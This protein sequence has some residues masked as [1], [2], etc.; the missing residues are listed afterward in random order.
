MINSAINWDIIFPSQGVNHFKLA[1]QTRFENGLYRFE[2]ELG[3][4]MTNR[5]IAAKLGISSHTAG[6]YLNLALQ[7]LKDSLKDLFH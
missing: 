3:Y 7:R 1:G 2:V 6:K 5:E 4:H